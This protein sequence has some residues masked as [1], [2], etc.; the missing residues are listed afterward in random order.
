VDA[1]VNDYCRA[2][3]GP[4]GDSVRRYFDRL[5]GLMNEAAARKTKAPAAFTPEALAGLRKELDQARKEAG[6][7]P[8]IAKRLAF[9]E[10]GLRWTAVEARAHA[11][12]ADSN[13]GK[14]AAKQTLDERFALMR[15]VFQKTPLALNVAYIGWGEDALWTRLGWERPA[16]AGKP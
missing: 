12:L 8:V 16:P 13:T 1:L 3:F 5:E 2:G 10:L 14:G 6:D 15:E 11:L 4:A 9:L 7:D